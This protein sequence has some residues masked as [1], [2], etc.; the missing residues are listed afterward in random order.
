[1]RLFG[2]VNEETV[3]SSRAHRGFHHSQGEMLNP[4][5][6]SKRLL[7]ETMQIYRSVWVVGG[8]DQ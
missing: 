7:H 5:A 8:F 2:S 3:I 1:M 4:P 6:Q